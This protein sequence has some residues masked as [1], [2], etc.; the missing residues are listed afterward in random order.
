MGKIRLPAE[1]PLLPP[2]VIERD[3]ANFSLKSRPLFFGKEL[4]HPQHHAE[5]QILSNHEAWCGAVDKLAHIG[6]F[7]G[8][9]FL[10]EH[11]VRNITVE[12]IERTQAITRIGTAQILLH[13]PDHATPWQ[14]KG[15]VD[16]MNE[17]DALLAVSWDMPPDHGERVEPHGKIMEVLAIAVGFLADA[18]AARPPEHAI[19]LCNHPFRLVQEFV[20]SQRAIE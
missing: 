2:H 14:E 13:F 18:N 20:L 16:L 1:I 15:V 3:E 10:I 9:R 4:G 6:D 8:E 19:D 12:G 7:A 5:S 17:I 11:P